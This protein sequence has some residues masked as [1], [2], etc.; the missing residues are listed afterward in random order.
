VRHSRFALLLVVALLAACESGLDRRYLDTTLGKP[1]ELPPDLSSVDGAS[2]FD[3]P[4]VF[5]SD[6][7]EVRDKV[8]VLARVDSLQ[9]N[10]SGDLYWLNVEEPATSLYQKIKN[11]WAF[12]GYG[13][14][15][16][17]P[18][19]GIMQTEWVY[20][21][22]GATSKDAAWWKNLF[23]TED[24]SAS[25]DQFRT[26]IE[27][28]PSGKGSRVYI[29]HRGTEYV[30][31]FRLGDK[32]STGT[33]NDWGFRASEPELEVEM[34]SR[35]MI[36][37]GLQQE[38]VDEQLANVRLFKPRAMMEVDSDEKSPY[39][40]LLDP[41]QIAWNR[42]R[43]VL[44]RLNF[45]IE[46]SEYKSGF[47]G[48]GVL[49]VKA[50]VVESAE[51]KGFLGFGTEEDR[52]ERRFTLVLSEEDHTTTRL[53]LEDEKGNFDTTTE[54]SQFISLLYEQIK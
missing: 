18:V 46:V 21:E 11:F 14:V 13:L 12:E 48:E 27:R 20:K 41:Y 25:Q 31:E 40:L 9:L 29:T 16:D 1:L 43:H 7:P 37:L 10:G 53:I 33:V 4:N 38:S 3:L 36:Y 19:I 54:G 2:N 5:V 26:R 8:P 52:R 22:E 30:H 49:I 34:L 35:L 51:N 28:D 23:A 42:V 6:D 15:I 32:N 39:L 47:S 50:Q 44:E 24:L 17:E 45:E